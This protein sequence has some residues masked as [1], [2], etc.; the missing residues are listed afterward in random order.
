ME[1]EN[2][3]G[4]EKKEAVVNESDKSCFSMVLMW[5][6]TPLFRNTIIIS[7]VFALIIHILYSITAPF[8]FLE[9]EWE[10]G[11]ILT[12][13]STIALGLLAI[14]QNQKFKEESDK[15]Q[16]VM[17]RQ[18]AEAQARLERINIEANE[19]SLI[20]RIIDQENQYLIRLEEAS[21]SFLN[22][23][24]AN[25][26][27]AAMNKAID[28]EDPL[29]VTDASTEMSN[30]YIRLMATYLS[31]MKADGINLVTLMEAFGELHE[32]ATAFFTNIFKTQEYDFSFVDEHHPIFDKAENTLQVFLYERRK[33]MYRILT[34]KMTL[35]QVRAIYSTIEG[36]ISR[37]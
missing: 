27:L 18:N 6:K 23:S 21:Y 24:S 37:F 20:S 33:L 3:V 1:K 14:W 32:K 9:H 35:E 36:D 22:T 10:A 12:Y 4:N 8:E 31:G 15:A 30:A 28:T 29:A 7:S 26:L 5:F 16:E 11:D 25:T 13:V 34:E 17:E 19:L 2:K